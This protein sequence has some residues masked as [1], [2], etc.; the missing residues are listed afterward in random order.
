ML[1][2]DDV[3][4][5]EPVTISIDS[6]RALAAAAWEYADGAGTPVTCPEITVVDNEDPAGIV[7]AP[8]PTEAPSVEDDDF[9]DVAADADKLPEPGA[10]TP[11][12]LPGEEELKELLERT[13]DL[14]E[15]A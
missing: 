12:F 11:A 1:T 6:Y 10:S 7:T 9:F 5:T 15:Q 2:L 13:A 4:L 8:E 3:E 14:D